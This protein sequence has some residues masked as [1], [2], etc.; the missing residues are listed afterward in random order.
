MTEV[1]GEK[2]KLTTITI[3][4]LQCGK[5]RVASAI[6]FGVL[7]HLDAGLSFGRRSLVIYMIEILGR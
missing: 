3:C 5:H 4:H 1:L 2:S 6:V 7:G